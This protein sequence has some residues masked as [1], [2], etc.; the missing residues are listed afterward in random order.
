LQPELKLKVITL[1]GIKELKMPFNLLSAFMIEP[2]ILK[3]REEKLFQKYFVFY[4]LDNF[5]KIEIS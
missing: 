2:S 4:L 5:K 3:K 1:K